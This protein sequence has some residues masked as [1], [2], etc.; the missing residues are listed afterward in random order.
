M[1]TPTP[2]PA[3][4]RRLAALAFLAGL[5]FLLGLGTASA[6]QIIPGN[7]TS[8]RVSVNAGSLIRLNRAAATVFV[9]NPEIADIQV[10]SPRLIYLLGKK[11]GRTTV[12]AVDGRDNVLASVDVVVEHN[13]PGLRSAIRGL[14]P[15][16]DV[17]VSS[18][19]DSIVI[20]GR[21]DSA[22]ASEN[23]RRI[24][25]RYLGEEE[26]LINRVGVD[27]PVQ[28]NLRVRVAEITRDIQKQLGFNWEFVGE[29]F[30]LDF[31]LGIVN[32]FESLTS[33]FLQLSAEPGSLDANALIDALDNEGMISILAE[34]NLTAM[35]GETASFLAGGEFPILVPQGDDRVTI[36]FKKF[37]VSLA[38]TPTIVGRDRVNLHVLPEVSQLTDEGSI[39][40]QVGDVS[41]DV[42]ALTTRRAETTVELGS[43]QS[44]AV[45]GLLQNDV[46]E[47]V[48]KFPGLSDVP[49]LGRLFTS[50][51]FIRK[52]SELVII[53]TPYIVRPSP[54]RLA[55]PRDGFAPLSDV[56][57]LFPGGTMRRFRSAGEPSSVTPDGRRIYGPVGFIVK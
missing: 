26:E 10:K 46:S 6:T 57:R 22:T 17:Q 8:V 30:G 36:E 47:A 35:S 20:D 52:E 56:E 14:Y 15:N 54:Q 44:F 50:D 53:I 45:A 18:V 2:K 12:Y 25:T 16:A 9:A 7:Q 34:P 1:K 3:R 29:M 38:F 37:G 33:N 43:G 48:Q 11:T 24:A 42:P 41:I 39:S 23:L 21:V 32:P 55:T 31:V 5:A 4:S 27:A 40:L 51:Q 28:V 19:E 13:L 49:V